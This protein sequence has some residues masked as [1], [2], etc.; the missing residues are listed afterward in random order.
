[1]YSSAMIREELSFTTLEDFRLEQRLKKIVNDLS[2]APELSIPQAS[3]DWAAAKGAYRFLSSPKATPES[4]LH[5]HIQKTAERIEQ[6]SQILLIQDTSSIDYTSLKK[7]KGLG[8]LDQSYCYGIKVH[9]NLAITKEGAVLGILD[10]YSWSRPAEDLGKKRL[11]HKKPTSEKETQVWIDTQNRAY[12]Q[13]PPSTRILTVADREADFYDLLAAPRPSNV[14]LLIRAH[15]NRKIETSEQ[16]LFETLRREK[17]AG[18]ILLKVGRGPHREPRN[19]EMEIRFIE[20]TLK[21]PRRASSVEP[22]T[23]RAVATREVRPPPK[24]APLEW[25]LLTTLPVETFDQAVECVQSYAKRWLIERFHFTLKSGCKIEEL[26]LETDKRLRNALAIY[27]LVAFFLMHFL[28]LARTQPEASA[29][30]VFEESE[31]KLLYRRYYPRGRIPA[32][33]PP[34]KKVIVW[35]ARLGGFLARKHDKDPGLKTLW[36]GLAALHFMSQV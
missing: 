4:I 1:M 7:T 26:Q 9:T 2:R 5:S 25:I 34:L 15:H 11:R 28:Y 16:P 8:Y 19:T 23:I 13:V 18:R 6:H 14:D 27:S 35:V 10:Q 3:Q 24:E 17:P 12:A 21:A 30:T 20:V 36:K 29:Q 22:L 33:P 32:Q 31:W